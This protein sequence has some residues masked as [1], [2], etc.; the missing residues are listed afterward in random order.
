MAGSL[1]TPKKSSIPRWWLSAF[2][3]V[4]VAVG[5]AIA[6]PRMYESIKEARLIERAGV[7]VSGS[8]IRHN[9]QTGRNK[10]SSSASVRYSAAGQ[11]YEVSVTG[12]GALPES[13]PVGTHAVVVFAGSAPAI[14]HATIPGASTQRSTWWLIAGLWFGAA[15]LAVVSRLV[16]R[17]EH[18]AS[19]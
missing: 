3:S 9:P 1:G 14:A 17:Y 16:W 19:P 7:S 8:V 12:C 2:A 13:S 15:L 18:S 6:T 11:P 5:A 4:L 10:C